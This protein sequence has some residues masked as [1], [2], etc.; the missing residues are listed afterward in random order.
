MFRKV[1]IAILAVFFTVA[2]V[3]H[4]ISPGTYLP[5]MPDYLPWHLGL[6]YLSGAAEVLGG[7]GICFPKWRKLAG[8]GLIALLVAVFPA[9]VQMLTHQVPL[10]GKIVPEWVLWVRLPLQA[11]MIAWVYVSCV[12]NKRAE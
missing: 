11:V 6:I 4:F 3:N 2:G 7:I 1:S 12:K 8:W 9:N 5:M 10:N